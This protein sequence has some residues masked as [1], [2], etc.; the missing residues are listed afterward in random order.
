MQLN[1]NLIDKLEVLMQFDLYSRQTGIKIHH[2]ARP[3]LILAAE[4]LFEDGFITQKD[5]GYLTDLGYEAAEHLEY[6]L[7]IMQSEC[8]QT[9]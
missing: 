7:E 8:A 5:G 9:H 6:L 3:G 4:Q 1:P 2:T